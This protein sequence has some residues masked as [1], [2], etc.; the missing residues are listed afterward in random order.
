MPVIDHTN[1][2][3]LQELRDTSLSAWELKAN[4]Y[5]SG[6]V[7]SKSSK[8]STGLYWRYDK[9]YFMS[10]QVAA[11]QAGS[12][13]PVAKYAADTATFQIPS[14]HLSVAV[15]TDEIVEAS[16]T[17]APLNDAAL[18]LGNNFVVDY[19]LDFANNFLVDDV[20]GFQAEGV[21][22][23]VS[24]PVAGSNQVAIVGD[25]TEVIG[26]TNPA[27]FLQFDDP[28]SDPINI[29][30]EAIRTIQLDT[31]L[32]PNK[33]M[34]PRQVMDKIR[35][36]DQVNQ[37]AANTL[38]INGGESQVKTILSQHLE[39]ST[40]NIVVVEMVYQ[41]IDSIN[42][43][44]RDVQNHNFGQSSV[45]TFATDGLLGNGMNWMVEKAC[46]LM[47]NEMSFSKYAR[48]AA[49]CFKWDGLTNALAGENPALNMAG[50]IDT[51]NLMIRSRYDEINFTHYI[52]GYFAYDNEI[53]TPNLGF[54][55]KNAIS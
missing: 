10:T 52:D 39:I 26:G 5:A 17:L 25:V 31:G 55:F 35:D 1:N 36:N 37:Y 21:G 46:L 34:I 9:Q 42:L 53:V 33:L 27:Q 11:R 24:T 38:G 50:G 49:A 23:I 47:Y 45:P 7:P 41:K 2:N 15:T 29:F 4:T 44:D 13:P 54:Y 43:T 20:W 28:S 22:T 32:R 16:D 51:P 12:V 19:E 6:I 40:E 14:K 48:T 18:F 3:I 8:L 30:L